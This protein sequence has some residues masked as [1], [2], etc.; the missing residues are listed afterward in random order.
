MRYNANIT[1][2]PKMKA[3]IDFTHC[4]RGWCKRCSR[5]EQIDCEDKL[6]VEE[7]QRQLKREELHDLST[8]R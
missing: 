4:E 5:E 7:Y 1:L 2:P 6:Q 3:E 8:Q